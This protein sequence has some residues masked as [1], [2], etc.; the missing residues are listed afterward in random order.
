MLKRR[1]LESAIRH[2]ALKDGKMAFISGPR[3]VGK[4]TLGKQLQNVRIMGYERFF[5]GLV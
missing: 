4:T 3:Q 5:S 1:Y 2:D